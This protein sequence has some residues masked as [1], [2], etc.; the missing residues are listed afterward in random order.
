[1]K[2]K[3]KA[4]SM[5]ALIIAGEAIFLLPFILIRVFK[6]IIREAFILSDF[7]IGKAQAVYGVTAM[8][9]Y[10]FGGFFAD[11][12]E[13]RKLLA[14]SLVLTAIGGLWMISIPS[15]ESL[16]I[17]Y[18]FWG[19]STILLF[20]AALIKATREWGNSHNQ[21]ISF[22]LLDGG[23]GAFAAL[24]ATFGSFIPLLFFP[25]DAN[26][27]T[28]E[29][30]VVTM[31]YIIGFITLVVFI[32][33]LFTWKAI[34]K[35]S[36]ST[37]SSEKVHFDAYFV[38][39]LLRKP[40]IIYHSLIIV[41]AYAAY[42]LTGTYA[43]YAKDVW[44]YTLQEASYFGVSIQWM[45]P[46][47]A[48]TL[49]WIADKYLASKLS[50]ISFSLMLTSSVILGFGLFEQSIAFSM[51]TFFMMVV[52]TYSLR[53]LYFAII[54]EAKTPANI[55][56]TVV[57]IISVLG[58]T[59]DIFMSLLSGYM[60]GQDPTIVEYQNLFQLFIIFPLIGLLATIGFRRVIR[61]EG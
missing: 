23:R 53:G 45:R 17:L 15:Y 7:Q 43:T 61:K 10:F 54:E 50:M 14:T 34:P 11:K 22:G 12:L 37:S 46:I 6:P 25:E 49:G 41:C 24:I 30:K 31:Q 1:M 18:G 51:V 44:D 55:T 20:W 47:A 3:S 26:N 35:P 28:Q 13:A 21:G 29:D 2:S 48:V 60:L 5:F 9:S 42:K 33:A 56:G 8:I 59:P 32:V 40:K 4:L 58:F 16:R 38:F 39:S 57:G 52:G 36:N 19:V 27:I